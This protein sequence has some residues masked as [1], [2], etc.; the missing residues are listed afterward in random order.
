MTLYLFSPFS[1]T[2]FHCCAEAGYNSHISHVTKASFFLSIIGISL[3]HLIHTENRL[4]KDWTTNAML[5]LSTNWPARSV[6]GAS[7]LKDVKVKSC[8]AG[9]KSQFAMH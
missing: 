3:F 4:K 2:G 8:A 9:C 6:E 7:T 1:R 5:Q